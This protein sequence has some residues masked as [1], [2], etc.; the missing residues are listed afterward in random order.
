MRFTETHEFNG[1]S[2]PD[3]D[4]HISEHE[5]SGQISPNNKNMGWGSAIY[6]YIWS[7]NH[8]KD[9]TILPMNI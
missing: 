4:S 3:N 8:S 2:K 6:I 1:V 5:S 7:V 9:I